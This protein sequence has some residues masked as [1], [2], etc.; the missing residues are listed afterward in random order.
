MLFLKG[1]A[2]EGYDPDAVARAVVNTALSA[3]AAIMVTLIIEKIAIAK[4]E[5]VVFNRQVYYYTI[6]G[7]YWSITGA[8]NGGLTGMVAICAGCNVV[9][10]WAGFVIGCISACAYTMW[11]RIYLFLHIDDPLNAGPVHLGG[12]L[13]GVISVALF[14]NSDRISFISDG[15]VLYA[16]DEN[17]F[18]FLGIQALGAAVIVAW[19]MVLTAILFGTLRIFGALRVSKEH[20][21]EG[22]DFRNGEPAYPL[23]LAVFNDSQASS[24]AMTNTEMESWDGD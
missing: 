4:M 17:A 13:W 8:I 18:V 2:G 11:S 5:M 19:T 10:P 23:D 3:S 14:A 12:G 22:L 15:G 6:F 7:G 1:I 21:R 24:D 16:W 9:E 20:E